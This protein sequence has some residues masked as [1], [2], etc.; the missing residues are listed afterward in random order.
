MYMYIPLTSTS[1]LTLLTKC[2]DLDIIREELTAADQCFVS[3]PI[4]DSEE[5]QKLRIAHAQR[6]ISSSLN[7]NIWQPFSSEKT[8]P[9]P[10]FIS[11]LSEIAADLAK[12]CHDGRTS[13]RAASVWTALTMRALESL[14]LASLSS[15]ASTSQ[16]SPPPH[17]S[18]QSPPPRRADK[19]VDDVLR[20]LS[21]IVTPSQK[22]Q[23]QKELLALVDLSIAVWRSAQTDELKIIVCP[24][25]DR[26]NRNE[27]RYLRFDPQSSSPD[28][29]IGAEIVSSTHPRI[30]TLFPRITA[31]QKLS[32]AAEPAT[33]LPGSWPQAQDEPRTIET[34]I[35]T[36]AGLPEWSPLVVKG[37]EEEEERRDYL[38]DEMVRV[39][40]EANVRSGR[41]N[42][43]HSRKGSMAGSGSG[44][45]SQ[46]A[47]FMD[48]GGLMRKAEE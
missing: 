32:R 26:A 48:E 14:S 27:W 2:Q 33:G 7:K 41:R 18:G 12:P 40:Q 21:P 15:Q 31:V 16:G 22:G 45:P 10:D 9:H 8:L 34:C 13:G 4:S 11:L 1:T 25:L 36:G 35:H 29:D 20:V 38:H 24:N 30:F 6:V 37:K 23:L 46:I 44:P 5:S 43:G 17:P 28:E 42:S 47:Q 3:V 19:V 39:R